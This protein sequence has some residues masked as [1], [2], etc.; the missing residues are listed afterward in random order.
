MHICLFHALRSMRREISYEKLEIR[1]GERDHALE[2][3]TSL[4]YATSEKEYDKHYK[5]LL[6]TCPQSLLTYYN[7]NWHVTRYE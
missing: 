4:A 6:E 3:L 5:T 1:P 2:L 7:F